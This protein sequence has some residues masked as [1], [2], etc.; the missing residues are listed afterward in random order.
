[1]IKHD[2]LFSIK[3]ELNLSSRK[4][5]KIANILG[6]YV[7]IE[8][9]FHEALFQKNHAVQEFF[10]SKVVNLQV[11]KQQDCQLWRK[12]EIGNLEDELGNLPF[13]N[14]VFSL[15]NSSDPGF[16]EDN[17][18][19]ILSV[20]GSEVILREKV[21]RKRKTR[22]IASSDSELQKWVLTPPNSQGYFRIVHIASRKVLT[23]SSD[24]LKIEELASS[25][26][27]KDKKQLIEVRAESV[28]EVS[29]SPIYIT[30]ST[31][32][33]VGLSFCPSLYSSVPSHL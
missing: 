17:S 18:N 9:N 28:L 32:T 6:D 20:E 19:S 23:S 5:L 7:K 25:K 33:S 11:C 15:P 31:I 22:S 30:I 27:T 16:I 26:D 2:T 24:S 21:I 12:N 10:T 29:E 3:K 14:K 8:E 1:V 4:V 13:K